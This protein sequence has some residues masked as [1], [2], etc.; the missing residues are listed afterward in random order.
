MYNYTD[1]FK[2]ISK[3]DFILSFSKLDQKMFVYK[4]DGK[5]EY[6]DYTKEIE[7]YYLARLKKQY[8][9]LVEIHAEEKLIELKDQIDYLKVTKFISEKMYVTSSIYVMVAGI[10]AIIFDSTKDTDLL[11]QMFIGGLPVL[12]ISLAVETY[13]SL[14]QINS[15][16][17]KIKI[18]QALQDF[19]KMNLLMQNEAIFVNDNI[20]I[21]TIETISLETMKKILEE[22]KGQ[23]IIRKKTI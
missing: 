4:A 20:D 9:K 10:M 3:E 12:I 17:R 21:N 6:I 16:K 7:E 14:K 13:A 1:F 19:K 22:S 15:K 2:D 8:Q 23:N 11:Y 5:V 18:E